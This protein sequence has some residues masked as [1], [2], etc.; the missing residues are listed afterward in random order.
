ML[1]NDKLYPPTDI[2]LL[3]FGFPKSWKKISP[4]KSLLE[5]YNA[6]ELYRI[7]LLPSFSSPIWIT[8]GKAKTGEL[9]LEILTEEGENYYFTISLYSFLSFKIKLLFFRIWEFRPIGMFLIDG[10]GYWFEF[11]TDS[12]YNFVGYGYEQK[13]SRYKIVFGLFLKILVKKLTQEAKKGTLPKSCLVIF[14]D[15]LEGYELPFLKKLKKI[16]NILL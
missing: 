16:G 4:R 2:S 3:E 9:F 5:L 11:L 8:I 13:L 1:K 6:Y 10:I 7:F 14:K 12:K 15:M